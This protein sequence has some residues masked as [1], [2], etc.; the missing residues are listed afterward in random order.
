MK[1]IIVL[2]DAEYELIKNIGLGEIPA[3]VCDKCCPYF[4][5][6]YECEEAC[7]ARTLVRKAAIALPDNSK[8]D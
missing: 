1:L 5:I 3:E 6:S 7:P 8:S 2:D 4:N